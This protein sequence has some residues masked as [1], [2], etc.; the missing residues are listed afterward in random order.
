MVSVMVDEKHKEYFR[1]YYFQYMITGLCTI[2]FLYSEISLVPRGQNI[3]FSLDDP[4]ITKRYVPSELVGPLGCLILSVGL[5]NLVV[6]W[7]CM[8]DK[9]QLKKNRVT[10]LRE[11]PDGISKDFHFMHTSLLCL[12]LI[13][14]INAAVTG[15][16]KLIIGNLRPDF[17]DRCMPDL[18]KISDSDSSVFGLDICKQTNKWVL[19]EGLK[20]T[21]SG[22]S[23]FIVSTMGFTYLWQKAFTTRTA[24][25]YIWCPLLAL[26]VM[27]SRVVDHRHHWYDVVSGAAL[28]FLVIY[29]C[30]KWTFVNVAKRDI[31]PSP[32]SL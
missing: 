14:S 12:M 27:V 15:A 21:P 18:Q 17:V 20:S 29:A 28:A 11:R 30:W 8:F 13:I 23:S 19:Y 6:L 4:S 1:L 31:L 32:V 22:H 5:S 3:Q 25:S 26:V 7:S 24:R 16:L 2:L 9:D 10:W